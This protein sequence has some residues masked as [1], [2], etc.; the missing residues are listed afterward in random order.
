MSR[1]PENAFVFFWYLHVRW[2][3]PAKSCMIYVVIRGQH[4]RQWNVRR[5]CSHW[6]L[7]VDLEICRYLK[8]ETFNLFE[9]END[10]RIPNRLL[11]VRTIII[12]ISELHCSFVLSRALLLIKMRHDRLGW[13]SDAGA[14]SRIFKNSA[15]HAIISAY[16]DSSALGEIR[17]WSSRFGDFLPV[18]FSAL[19]M[20]LGQ[21][22]SLPLLLFVSLLRSG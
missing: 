3:G 8:I 9:R 5:C 19:Y 2:K 13:R 22:T 4:T 21:T 16:A 10:L 6:R 14:S 1:Q 12:I 18:I 17:D 7:V 11:P 15:A 20:L